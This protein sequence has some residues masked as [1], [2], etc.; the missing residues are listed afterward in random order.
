MAITARSAGHKVAAPN[1]R[2]SRTSAGRST[3]SAKPAARSIKLHAAATEV[4]VET[5]TVEA[6]ELISNLQEAEQAYFAERLATVRK[7]FPKALSVD[8]FIARVEMALC[9]FGLNSDNTIA[10]TNLCRDEVTAV[11]KTKI[12]EVYGY[13]FNTNGLGGVLS[14]G[15]TGMRAGFSHS[16]VCTQNKERYVFFGFPHI[17]LDADGTVG[18]ISRP[19]RAGASCACGALAA[20]LSAMKSEGVGPSCKMPGVHDPS[21]PELSILKQRLARRITYEGLDVREMTLVDMTK[22]CER[23]ITDDL[24]HLIEMTVVE[25]KADYAVVTGVQI[26]NWSPVYEDDAPNL[27]WVEPSAVYVVK[28]GQRI[29]IDLSAVPGLTPRQLRIVSS[30]TG[31][32][33][34]APSSLNGTYVNDSTI[35]EVPKAPKGGSSISRSYVDLLSE[36]IS[37]EEVAESA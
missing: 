17:G 35:L 30:V 8:D 10:M 22:C 23:V 11:L 34:I 5:E 9:A 19:G 28:D 16:P 13:S 24:Q 36:I 7:H 25:A 15:A 20:S 29:D 37:E 3:F 32:E 33:V 1:A 2:A 12:D 6:A 21:D 31:S 18:A 14:C 26:H 27:E 4:E